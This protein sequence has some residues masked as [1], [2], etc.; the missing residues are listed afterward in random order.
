MND[1]FPNTDHGERCPHGFD[2]HDDCLVCDFG[3]SDLIV[4]ACARCGGECERALCEECG[5]AGATEPG[6]LHEMDPLM[7]DE[8]ET[9]PCHQCGGVGGWWFCANSEAWCIANP[10]PGRESASRGPGGGMSTES[11][12]RALDWIEANEPNGVALVARALSAV[13]SEPPP[14]VAAGQATMRA[15]VAA[16]EAALKDVMPYVH[17]AAERAKWVAAAKARVGALQPCSPG[18]LDDVIGMVDESDA[19]IG[20]LFRADVLAA[21]GGES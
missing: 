2:V 17:V 20:W 11:E 19:G 13:L 4:P 8:D 12:L 18:R 16:L 5:G 14:D 15:R 9:K 7:H 3:E 6:E 1:L 21:I 10:K